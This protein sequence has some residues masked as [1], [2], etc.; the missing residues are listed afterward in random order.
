M[1]KKLKR[2]L[3]LMLTVVLLALPLGTLP[4]LAVEPS[5]P[6][7]FATMDDFLAA[8]KALESG[9]AVGHKVVTPTGTEG[10]FAIDLYVA[11]KNETPKAKGMDI[12]FV[13]DVSGSMSSQDIIR[14]RNSFSASVTKLFGSTTDPGIAATSRVALITYNDDTMIADFGSGRNWITATTWDADSAVLNTINGGNLWNTENSTA[15]QLGIHAAHNLLYNARTDFAPTDGSPANGQA[16]V[17]MTDGGPNRVYLGSK[18]GSEI[19]EDSTTGYLMNHTLSPS[20]GG[21][22]SNNFSSN[23]GT[24]DTAG[25]SAD[26]NTGSVAPTIAQA[27][28]A[29]ADGISVYAIGYGNKFTNNF[30]TNSVADTVLR[31]LGTFY[32]GPTNGEELNALLSD[33]TVTIPIRLNNVQIADLIGAGFGLVSGSLG[34][35]QYATGLNDAAFDAGTATWNSFGTV[36]VPAGSNLTWQLG[37]VEDGTL[38]KLS[39]KVALTATADGTY[40]TNTNTASQFVDTGNATPNYQTGGHNKLTYSVDGTNKS[41]AIP[42]CEPYTIYPPAPKSLLAVDKQVAVWNSVTGAADEDFDY[43]KTVFVD[44]EDADTNDSVDFVYRIIITNTGEAD[45]SFTFED[46]LY[47]YNYNIYESLPDVDLTFDDF[48]SDVL[49]TTPVTSAMLTV[50]AGGSITLYYKV[51]LEPGF[52][53]YNYVEIGPGSPNTDEMANG[54]SYESSW[55]ECYVY[56]IDNVIIG[57]DK[58]VAWGDLDAAIAAGEANPN[59]WQ[60]YIARNNSTSETFTYRIIVSRKDETTW[61]DAQVKFGDVYKGAAIDLGK[62]T[63]AAGNTVFDVDADDYDL[64]WFGGETTEYVFYYTVTEGPG[65]YVNRATISEGKAFDFRPQSLAIDDGEEDEW[66]DP[67]IKVT[68]RPS[69]DEATV[70]ISNTPYIPPTSYSYNVV[71]NYYTQ[72]LSGVRSLDGSVNNGTVSTYSTSINADTVA[73]RVLTYG[74][75]AYAFEAASH[76]GTVS[77]V[78]GHVTITIDYV[79]TVID[80]EDPPLTDWPDDDI[81]IEDTAPPLADIPSTGDNTNNLL[82]LVLTLA[83]G[84]AL[85]TAIV[86]GKKIKKN[87][88]KE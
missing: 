2:A 84:G 83:F 1:N 87:A 52:D 6:G 4:A 26:G 75:E 58:T 17:I 25:A 30:T 33:V 69:F 61:I 12:V 44:T 51:T 29:I 82:Y 57:V 62:L 85:G 31:N 73:T 16:M 19:A 79:R 34:R 46:T 54:W 14:A 23:T 81:P 47:T 42:A 3:S 68:L 78:N 86:I 13:I 18:G 41:Q 39:F 72:G 21:G 77:L 35:P 71:H 37:T 22:S 43:W 76:T 65:T 24:G 74:G 59:N 55:A 40:Y 64:L 50:P 9:S 88:D 48:Y 38:Y 5:T 20:W 80:E 8:A 10:E 36:P 67:S 49:C 15:T 45:G 56:P 53:S 66:E 27:A 28:A 70:V 63:D 11:G 32:N 60:N 7:Y